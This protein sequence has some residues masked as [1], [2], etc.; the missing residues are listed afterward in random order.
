MRPIT[1]SDLMNPDVLTVPEDMPIPELA[2][3]LIDQEIT[4]APV[5]DADGNLVG[6]VSVVDIA[7]LI[8]DELDDDDDDDDEDHDDEAHEAAEEGLLLAEGDE[9]EDEDD[10]DDDEEL[11][12]ADIMTPQ[13][14]SVAEDATV[15]EVASLMLDCHLHRLV[16]T[17]EGEAVGIISTSDLLGL[18]LDDE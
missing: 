12:A 3:F 7:A 13:V 2:A 18:F 14:F 16:V 4:G 17:R 15:A 8:A 11:V 9:D 10:D 6:V 1:A 5:E